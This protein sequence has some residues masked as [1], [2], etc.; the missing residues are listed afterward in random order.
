LDPARLFAG[1]ESLRGMNRGGHKEGKDMLSI[2]RGGGRTLEEIEEFEP[3]TWISL[4][5]PTETELTM[6]Q[7][8]LGLELSFLM[9]ALDEEETSHIDT[10]D[11]QTLIVV[12]MPIAETTEKNAVVYYT[13]PI[14]IILTANHVITV[15]IKEVSTLQ[16]IKNGAV[17]NLSPVFKTQFVLQILLRAAKRYLYYLRQIDKISNYVEKQLHRSMKNKELF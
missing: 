5:G 1:R 15:S 17:K 13:L 12:D 11:D 16:D 6:V 2:Y 9:A 10:E 3:G 8:Q 14:G 7:E 4:T